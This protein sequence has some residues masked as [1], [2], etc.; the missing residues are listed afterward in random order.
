[1]QVLKFQTKFRILNTFQ[2]LSIFFIFWR[3]IS[4]NLIFLSKLL[5]Y[6]NW[7]IIYCKY[8]ISGERSSLST[9]I[10]QERWEVVKAETRGRR[11]QISSVPSCLLVQH[12]KQRL[13]FPI[14][15]RFQ[16]AAILLPWGICWPGDRQHNFSDQSTLILLTTPQKMLHYLYNKSFV[17]HSDA[18]QQ[19]QYSIS[20]GHRPHV[21]QNLNF[22]WAITYLIFAT[23]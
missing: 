12:R 11:S 9:I 19:K 3:I 2:F 10:F 16:H 22:K 13:P 15:Y 4:Q 14:R 7:I 6:L 1:M 20:L 5:H 17:G 8:L 21:I 23:M 18:L